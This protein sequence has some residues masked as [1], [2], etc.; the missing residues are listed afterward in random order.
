MVIK[1]WH[2]LALFEDHITS[3]WEGGRRKV[4]VEDISWDFLEIPPVALTF[5]ISFF[6]PRYISFSS[7]HILSV[8]FSSSVTRKCIGKHWVNCKAVRKG[9]NQTTDLLIIS[10]ALSVPCGKLLLLLKD[11][12]SGDPISGFQRCPV[13]SVREW[14]VRNPERGVLA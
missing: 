1:R 3:H 7:L 14:A 2:A 12:A 9:E 11:L 5:L 13:S 6:S 10:Q 8:F 4:T